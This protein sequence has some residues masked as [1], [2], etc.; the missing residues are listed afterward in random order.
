MLYNYI[1]PLPLVLVP[2]LAQADVPSVVTDI[3]PVQSIAAQIMDGVGTPTLLL[4]PRLDPH[5]FA[6]RPSQAR[7]LSQA[8]AVFWIGPDLTPGLEDALAGLSTETSIFGLLELP[9]TKVIPFVDVMDGHHDDHDDHH[10]DDHG[11]E[12]GDEHDDDHKDDHGDEHDHD[13]DHKDDH[14]E[15]GDDHGD[16]H[17]H[18]DD[19]DDEH[20]DDH[21]GHDDHDDHDHGEFDPHAWL[22]PENAITWGGVIAATLSNLDPENAPT[23]QANFE[24]LSAEVTA[25]SNRVTAIVDAE[26]TP[27]LVVVHDAYGY[28]VDELGLELIG[29]VTLSDA[30][31]P[32]A[33]RIAELQETVSGT[34]AFCA[35]SSPGEAT[36]LLVTA[37][38][39]SED[40]IVSL[41]VFGDGVMTYA[42]LYGAL[43][44]SLTGCQR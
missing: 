21:A 1:R 23:Y 42:E 28:L 44:D 18:K 37:T 14:D 36:D 15:H 19:H 25:A 29:A 11:D 33:R 9:E 38:G 24:T 27:P 41:D 40:E 20:G 43:G 17:G 4:A 8:D 3:A 32:G 30:T 10:D 2:T 34:A 12:H 6:V 26:S 39:V 7:A 31:S 22:S 35:I 16:E 5:S 13:E